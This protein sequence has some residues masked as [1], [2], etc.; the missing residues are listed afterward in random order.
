[1]STL[2]GKRILIVLGSLDLGGSERQAI[3]LARHLQHD[4]GATVEVWGSCNPGRATQLCDEYQIPWRIVGYGVWG[5]MMQNWWR[6]LVF[7]Y[8]ARRFQPDIILGFNTMPNMVCGLSWRFTGS[9]SFFWNQRDDGINRISPRVEKLAARLTP[10]FIANSP[11]SADFVSREFDVRSAQITII[12]NGVQLPAP[13]LTRVQWRQRLSLSNDD[14]VAVMVANLHYHKDHDA[15]VRAWRI[16]CDRWTNKAAMPCLLLAGRYDTEGG[17]LTEIIEDL[18]LRKEVRLLGPVKDVAGLL[19]A[20]DICVHSSKTEGCPNG[21]LEAMAAGLPVIGTDI[22]GI[23]FALSDSALD[24]LV[25]PG[26]PE[27]LAQK[28]LNLVA[29]PIKRQQFAET[30][31]TIA[32]DRFSPSRMHEAFSKILGTELLSRPSQRR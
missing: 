22:P 17:R 23:R 10:S 8:Q 27:Q 2:S 20:S 12:P 25:P 7:I 18:D 24:N 9:R 31:R 19:S 32:S 16:V 13:R 29:D 21:L 30:S 3:M 15:L 26:N 6:I 1:V 5:G 14:F 4:L 28:I 11:I